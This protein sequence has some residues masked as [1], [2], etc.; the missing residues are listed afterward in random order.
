M[1]IVTRRIVPIIAILFLL[2]G[3]SWA[4][5]RIATVDMRK[6]F[7]KYYKTDLAQKALKDR[8]ADLAKE[9]T[10]MREDYKK[11]GEEYRK[12]LADAGEQ[13]VTAE[14]RDK[15]KKEAEEKL[16]EL[17]MTEENIGKFEQQAR[18][19]LEEQNRRMRSNIIDEIRTVVTARAKSAGYSIVLDSS[20]D[21]MNGTPV[22]LFNA[23]D[24]DITDGVL[25]QLNA[26]APLE[27]SRPAEKT[28]K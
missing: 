12:L 8:G 10:S 28:D 25:T 4:Q 11:T 7:D 16:R 20:A 13:A 5:T 14:V 19:T 6:L 3:T 18:V 9:S 24:N 27:L 26:S 23:G 22:L 1:K 17:K 15:R 2:G 21:S